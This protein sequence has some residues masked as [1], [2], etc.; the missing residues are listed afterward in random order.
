MCMMMM[1]M[2]MKI[3][4]DLMMWQELRA[5]RDASLALAREQSAKGAQRADTGAG[6]RSE[7]W[8]R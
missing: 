5:D 4:D 2:M 3:D 1:M 7:P 8:H 6:C